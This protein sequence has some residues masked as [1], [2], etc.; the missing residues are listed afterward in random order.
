MN[1]ISVEELPHIQG[2]WDSAVPD[3]FRVAGCVSANGG[4]S[5]G[6][7][8]GSYGSFTISFGSDIPHENRMPYSVVYIWKRRS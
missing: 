2:S 8:N 5:S 6:S 7:N 1:C 4:K 3:S